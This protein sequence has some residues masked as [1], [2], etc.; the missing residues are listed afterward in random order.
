[1]D[2]TIKSFDVVV[3]TGDSFSADGYT[4]KT[5]TGNQGTNYT[6]FVEGNDAECTDAL[7]GGEVGVYMKLTEEKTIEPELPEEEE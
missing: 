5:I 1:M 4:F 6:V 7:I 2:K 3:G